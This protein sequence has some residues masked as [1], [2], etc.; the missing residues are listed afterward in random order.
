MSLSGFEMAYDDDGRGP[1]VMLLHGFPLDRSMWRE[2]IDF[3]SAHGFRAVAPDLRGL[4]ESVA[5]T[6]VCETSPVNHRLKSVPLTT[7][8]EMARDGAAL[9]D[10]LRIDSAVICGL[11]MGAYVAFEFAHLFPSRVL[12]L[13]L[14]GA[15][16]QGPDDAEK[17]SREEKAQQVLV[18]GMSGLAGGIV[19][20]M[21]AAKTL[22]EKPGVVERVRRMI[23]GTNAAGAAAA[24]RGMA[25][26]RDYSPDLARINAPTLII[27][28]SDDAVRKPDDAE[29]IHHRIRNS[30]RE[31]IDNA[32]HLMNMEQPKV[33][34][35]ALLN[36]LELIH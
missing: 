30:R 19:P 5:Q 20:Q 10:D 27:A 17:R 8:D 29:F 15:R 11:S 36:F 6:S 12:A 23:A 25:A 22:V 1:A 13:V 34:N 31:I 14:A 24:Q 32:G 3:L 21:L 18:E 9:L 4:G 7:M 28:G 2:Q 35:R 33:F 16:A 26:R